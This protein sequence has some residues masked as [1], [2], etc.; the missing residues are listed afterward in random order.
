MK[1]LNKKLED[2]I[3]NQILEQ[4]QSNRVEGKYIKSGVRYMYVVYSSKLDVFDLL[5]LES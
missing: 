1:R 3:R 4:F 2:E 5:N